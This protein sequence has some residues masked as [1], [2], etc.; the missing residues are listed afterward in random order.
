MSIT[1]KTTP[2]GTNIIYTQK[3]Y[4]KQNT[5]KNKTYNGYESYIPWSLLEYMDASI[6]Y[7]YPQGNHYRISP[8]PPT[9]INKYY[10]ATIKKNNIINIPAEIP[11]STKNLMQYTFIPDKHD[12]NT[13][14]QGEIQLKIIK[15]EIKQ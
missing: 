8:V 9:T 1:Y 3:I 12:I 10:T 14:Q 15:G 5:Y 7:I 4:S 11:V 2:N 13:N 6:I